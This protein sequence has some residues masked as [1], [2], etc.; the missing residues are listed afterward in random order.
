MSFFAVLDFGR[1]SSFALTDNIRLSPPSPS[2]PLPFP[3]S[4]LAGLHLKLPAAGGEG[5]GDDGDIV[6][7]I[8][9]S[10]GPHSSYLVRSDG[11]VERMYTGG[12]PKQQMLPEK[13][14]KYI[15][16]SAGEHA[17]YLLRD[18]GVVC[19]TTG[20]GKISQE[21]AA[22]E[23]GVK[24]IQVS[25]GEHASYLLRDDGKVR[26]SREQAESK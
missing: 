19:R 9:A 8:N 11:I 18:D 23:K 6:T 1:Q 20:G 3:R 13:G 24:Y 14:T 26:A 22:A 17:S 10:A 15:M 12:K 4:T 16:V 2:P 5:K 21:M 7:Y 25:S